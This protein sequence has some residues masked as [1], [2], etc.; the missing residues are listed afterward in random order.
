[1]QVVDS[2]NARP[3]DSRRDRHTEPGSRRGSVLVTVV[4]VTLCIA[5]VRFIGQMAGALQSMCSD[6]GQ[7][8]PL[9]GNLTV[10]TARTRR[11]HR[12]NVT[13][14]LTTHR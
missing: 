4:V 13:A 3:A 5:G 11:A 14:L 10:V 7:L 6:L 8:G 12:Q 9:R 1:M 2:S